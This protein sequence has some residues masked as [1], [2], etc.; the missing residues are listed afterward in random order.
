[1]TSDQTHVIVGAPAAPGGR[2]DAAGGGIR[3]ARRARR[4][5]GSA[6]ASARRSKDYLRGEARV[7]GV[8]ARPGLLCRAGDRSALGPLGGEPRHRAQGAG[9]R[10]RR[11]AALRPAAADDGAEPAAALDTGSRS[12]RSPLPAHRRIR[13]PARAAGSRHERRRRRGRLDRIRGRSLRP[14]AWP[15]GHRRRAGLGPAR[16]R[17]GN[18]WAPSTA[19]CT[20]TMASGCAWEP[21]SRPSRVSRPSP[22]FAPATGPN[23]A[24]TSSSSGS[25]S[26]RVRSWRGR[27]VWPSTTA[28]SWTSTCKRAC[29]GVR[30][31]RRRQRSSPVLRRAHSRRALGQ[32]TQPGPAAAR[33]M[34]GGSDAYER[35]PYFFSDQ[36]DVG[37]VH[38]FARSWDRVVFRG[39]PRPAS[40]S[41]SGWRRI[42]SLQA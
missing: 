2:R 4:C 15:R 17:A 28:S 42:A 30:R 39:D 10:Q 36:Y 22:E 20:R 16:A 29:R 8:R 38:R 33:N 21:V 37:M 35:L 1:M 19:T 31:R 5:G 13:H 6:P 24:A 23:W 40:S 34:L 7:Q 26:S 27:P 3:R 18:C 25:A 41:R 14:P 12:R 9:P 11:A 32:R